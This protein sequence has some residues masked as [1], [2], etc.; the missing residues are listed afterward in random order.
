VPVSTYIRPGIG[1][2]P[3]RNLGNFVADISS[4]V[5]KAKGNTDLAVRKMVFEVFKRIVKRTPVDTGRARGGWQVAKVYSLYSELGGSPTEDKVV[6][7]RV[8]RS[9]RTATGYWE[10]KVVTRV[11]TVSSNRGKI[12]V[13]AGRFDKTGGAT[14]RAGSN[15][16]L[17]GMDIKDGVIAYIFNNVR[18]IIFL[19]GGRVYPDP[20]YGSPQ[21]PKGMVRITLSEF[22]NIT[23]EVVRSISISGINYPIIGV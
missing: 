3:D 7:T 18:Y 19:E 21:A 17:D 6:W 1:V 20:P 4:F 10:G 23:D 9:Q 12:P 8:N 14:I 22:G 2:Q 16:I 15:F 13:G 11:R 5:K